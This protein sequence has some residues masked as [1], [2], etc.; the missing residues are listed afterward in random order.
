MTVAADIC[1][2]DNHRSLQWLA[3]AKSRRLIVLYWVVLN[4]RTPS[5]WDNIIIG[6]IFIYIYP[7]CKIKKY[8]CICKNSIYIYKYVYVYIYVYVYVKIFV[9]VNI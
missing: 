1:E 5:Y 2:E 4:H 8:T 3:L 9:Y 6:N 7:Y